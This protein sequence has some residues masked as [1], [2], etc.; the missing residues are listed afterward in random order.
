M[1]TLFRGIHFKSFLAALLFVAI[2][3]T[4]VSVKLYAEGDDDEGTDGSD[5]AQ[6]TVVSYFV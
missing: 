6:I 5:I 1:G 4:A 3:A 2:T